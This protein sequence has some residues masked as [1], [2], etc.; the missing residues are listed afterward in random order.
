[1][2][3]WWA[4]RVECTGAVA[5]RERSGAMVTEE[6]RYALVELAELA[7]GWNEIPPGARLRDIASRLVRTH[8]LRA[9]DAFQLAAALV[10]AEESAET[11]DLVTL[12]DRF[13]LAASREGFRVLPA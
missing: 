11:L 4:T 7:A 1:M 6:A 8:D 10:A 5:R 3:A 12:D 9:A 2:T 13:A